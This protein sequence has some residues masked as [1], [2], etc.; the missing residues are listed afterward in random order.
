M[1]NG[2]KY[3]VTLTNVI[4]CPVIMCNLIS[5]SQARRWG[6]EV[7]IDDDGLKHSQGILKI[8]QKTIQEV[9]VI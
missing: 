5:F 9:C 1:L 7:E 6:L 4:Y 3:T 2:H 8:I